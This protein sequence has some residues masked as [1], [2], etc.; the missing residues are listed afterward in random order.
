LRAKTPLN[1][2]R[3]ENM[4]LQKFHAAI[5]KAELP[6][7]EADLSEGAMVL[8]SHVF[9]N[10]HQRFSDVDFTK[11]TYEQAKKAMEAA[12]FVE[13]ADGEDVADINEG[14]LVYQV[15]RIAHFKKIVRGIKATQNRR[16]KFV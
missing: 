5:E 12:L 10:A 16:R 1:P 8:I 9:S 6:V 2:E 11:F 7:L 14:N 4:N 3:R 15:N 13:T